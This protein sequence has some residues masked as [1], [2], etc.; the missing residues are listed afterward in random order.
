MIKKIL[1]GFLVMIALIIL[2]DFVLDFKYTGV[3]IGNM[4]T[5][6]KGKVI[7]KLLDNDEEYL[8]IEI[9][10]GTYKNKYCIIENIYHD[11]DHYN[12]LYQINDKVLLTIDASQSI[13]KPDI[14][15]SGFAR[16]KYEL[17]LVIIFLLLLV[18]IGKKQG[19]K[20]AI[21]LILTIIIII[22]FMLPLILKGYSP[23]LAAIISCI[24]V[25]VLTLFIILGVSSK[26][27][28]T[29]IGTSFGVIAAGVL[30]YIIGDLSHYSGLSS[31]EAT[32]LMFVEHE[33]AFDFTGILFAGI[34]IGTLGAV[35]D[36][37]MSIASSMNEIKEN[38][39]DTDMMNLVKSGMNIGKDIMGT[40]TNTLILAYTGTSI[41]LLLFLIAKN[42]PLIII[43]NTE[44]ISTE[45][46]RALSGSIGLILSI[47]ATS[48]AAG[49]L[50]E[51]K[52]R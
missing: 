22:K 43:L 33:K 1:I 7:E 25:T 34:I 11:S 3:E 15:L 39:P 10:T 40:M 41:P 19:A 21:S 31:H 18:L 27:I 36:V 44:L 51:K 29:I 48:V 9:L 6:E 50:L 45:I 42:T 30:A 47:P 52:S 24:I 20:S 23:I 12:M 5:I 8:K 26:S 28:A 17:Y 35:M 4:K 13:E 14:E 16:D 49:L 2:V 32:S 37:S 46:I 38:N